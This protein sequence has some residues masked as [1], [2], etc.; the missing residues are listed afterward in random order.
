[1]E[2]RLAAIL[3]A[4]VVGYARLM[5][6]D[7]QATLAALVDCRATIDSEIA[8]HHG[9]IF[10]S[11]GDSLIAE[12]TS[13]VEAAQCAVAIQQTLASN[14]GDPSGGQ[15]M[16]FRI[17]VNLGD[18]TSDGKNLLGN[19]VNI[20]A[21][22]KEIAEPGGICLSGTVQDH[23]AGHPGLALEDAGEQKLKNISRPVRVWRWLL[24]GVDAPANMER[25]SKSS[26]AVLP[27]DN[28]S[29]D[30]EQQYFSDGLTEDIHH[31]ARQT[32]LAGRGRPQHHVRLQRT[33]DGHSQTGGGAG[34]R[35]RR[36]GFR[37]A[38]RT[39]HP[40]HRPVDRH[41]QRQ[42]CLGRKIRPQ[43]GGYLRPPG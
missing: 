25:S 41:D 13:P 34:R 18:V 35:L 2:R 39:T 16:R 29:G 37:A 21:R 26:V 23:L 1:M 15:P 10:G 11:A 9:R 17:G 19:G 4:D 36:R 42:P 32:P 43:A 40:G 22:L 5:E 38:R 28:M 8:E 3:A 30:P 33:G 27:F 24:D 14:I 12:F 6:A 7:E 20:A 31:R